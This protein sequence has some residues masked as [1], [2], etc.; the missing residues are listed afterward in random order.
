LPK[1]GEGGE[2]SPKTTPAFSSAMYDICWA[3]QMGNFFRTWCKEVLI[4][5]EKKEEKSYMQ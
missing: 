5:R 3:D 1:T 2:N 4:E